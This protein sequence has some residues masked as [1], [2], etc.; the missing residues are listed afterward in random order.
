MESEYKNVL[1]AQK[2]DLQIMLIREKHP[3]Y[4][5][6]DFK[7]YSD[8]KVAEMYRIL[9]ENENDTGSQTGMQTKV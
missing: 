8:M 5:D 3:V 1:A 9:V 2:R 6:F 7:R 4:F